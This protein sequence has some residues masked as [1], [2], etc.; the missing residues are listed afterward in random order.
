MK[1]NYWIGRIVL[2]LILMSGFTV[3]AQQLNIDSLIHITKTG[4]DD[5]N[6]VIAFRALCGATSNSNPQQ[7]IQYGWQGVAL[8]KKLFWDK[9]TAGCM[10]NVSIAYSNLGKYDSA[11]LILDTAL[12]YAKKVGEEKRIALIYINQASAYIYM[13]KLD[14][15]MQV[16]LNAVPYAEKSGDADRQA[17]VNM[18]IGNIYF[19]QEKWKNAESYYAKSIPLFE[20]LSNEN[21]VGVVTMN[22]SISQKNRN[23]LDTAE[24]YAYKSIDI[25]QRK[26]DI[27]NLI[28]AH[29]NLG[30]LLSYK[31][32]YTGAEKEYLLSINLAEQIG[33]FEQQVAN[34]QSLGDLYFQMKKYKQAEQLLLPIY[35]SA[36]VHKFYDEQFDIA[37]TLSSLYAETG[38][39]EKAFLFLKQ[40]NAAKDT[41]DNRKQ[42]EQ[43]QALQEQY[44]A[45]QREKEIALLNATNNLQQKEIERKNLI[46][47]LLVVI[48]GAL[49]VS[50]FVI[51]NRYTLKQQ[52]KE[53]QLRNK[54]AADLHDDVGATLSSI[55]MYSEIIKSKGK[56]LQS[57]QDHLLNKIINNSS[58]S[59]ESM[60]DIVWMVKPGNDKFSSLNNRIKHFAE[61]VCSTNNIELTTNFQPELAQLTL[62]MDMRRDVYLL[63]K[64]A[65]NNAAKYAHASQLDIVITYNNDTLQIAV[66]DNG[67]GFDTSADVHG[68][69][70][71]N[72][73]AR[74]AKYGGSCTIDSRQG[75]GTSVYVQ[76]PVK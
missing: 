36:V 34:K 19:Y 20:Q 32:N 25:L 4:V 24:I 26:N 59:I 5:T 13:G 57:E 45:D 40:L 22:M 7:S 66:T 10:L 64:E 60:S 49:V 54:I 38:N 55:K 1:S 27:E 72:M 35:D 17:R 73:H 71:S 67:K 65:V 9:G 46:T 74:A 11:V 16:A 18:T 41:I 47:I 48:F 21:M 28:L 2:C 50:G 39:Y 33:D 23:S 37:G 6:K 8:S 43:L 3:S 75:L 30:D 58:E 12:V 29:T 62:P 44:T 70:L 15:A 61:E 53:V 42:N 63:I 76:L 56:D 68:N 31:K 52:L 14:D 69:G 51:W